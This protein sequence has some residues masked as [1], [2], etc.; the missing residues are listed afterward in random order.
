MDAYSGDNTDWIGILNAFESAR[1]SPLAKDSA[2]LVLGAG[3]TARAAVYALRQLGLKTIY[4]CNRSRKNLEM[5]TAA[6]PDVVAIT[7]IEEASQIQS[8]AVAVSTVPADGELHSNLAEIAKTA[9][10]RRS[11]DETILVEMAYKPKLT[12]MMQIAQAS[13]VD[14]RGR[15]LN[16][17]YIKALSNSSSGQASLYLLRLLVRLSSGSR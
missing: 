13:R 1:Q 2:G 15:S 3:G 14:D 10:E 17:L 6:F 11:S 16:L 8:L 12:P 7:S 9:F 4:L 5:I